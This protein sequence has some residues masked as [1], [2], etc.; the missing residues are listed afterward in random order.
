MSIEPLPSDAL[1]LVESPEAQ[2]AQIAA[3]REMVLGQADL[4]DT[5]HE[6]AKVAGWEEALRQRK[7]VSDTILFEMTLIKFEAIRKMGGML[8]EIPRKPGART[9]R[10]TSSAHPTRLYRQVL[11]DLGLKRDQA[12]EWQLAAWCPEE[13][14]LEIVENNRKWDHRP[15]TLERLTREG[16][17]FKGWGKAQQEAAQAYRQNQEEIHR[18]DKEESLP[19]IKVLAESI[20]TLAVFEERV[21]AEVG[22]IQDSH[23]RSAVTRLMKRHYGEE[24]EAR[25]EENTALQEKDRELI[26]QARQ[27]QRLGMAIVDLS[28]L[29]KEGAEFRELATALQAL[30]G[31][32]AD[33]GLTYIPY[34]PTFAVDDIQRAITLLKKVKPV[35]EEA[36]KKGS[37]YA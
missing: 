20:P 15:I 2:L 33:S 7:G 3:V 37:N 23:T 28:K 30:R 10:R 19:K 5:L 36:E 12:S 9:D 34:P 27:L 35:L 21:A 22:P 14:F 18:R 16:R 25:K 26:D 11:Q 8:L 24:L 4:A 32:A 31:K 1:A 29:E 6:Y 17:Y 13:T